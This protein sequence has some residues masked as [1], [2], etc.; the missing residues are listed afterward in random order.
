M[1]LN[2]EE[3]IKLN[4]IEDWQLNQEQQAFVVKVTNDS[5]TLHNLDVRILRCSLA[6]LM[7]E[8]FGEE[9]QPGVEIH[10]YSLTAH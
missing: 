4:G 7:I 3:C 5:P 8:I 9:F 2:L 10:P 1:I 6:S